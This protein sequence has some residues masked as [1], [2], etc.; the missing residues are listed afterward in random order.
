M[1]ASREG[2][3]RRGRVGRTLALLAASSLAASV[4]VGDA[5]AARGRPAVAAAPARLSDTGLYADVAS[6]TVDPRNVPY[7]PQYPL[8]SDGASKRR[9]IRLPPGAAIDA[10]DPEAWEFP[11]GTR[12]WKEFAW[13][14]RVETRYLERTRTGWLFAAYAWLEDGSDAVRVDERGAPTSQPV[15]PGRTHV[16]PSIVDCKACHQNGR[17]A[18]LG[19]GALQ[20]SPDRDPLAP[21]REPLEPG[22][23]TLP[24]LVSRGLVRGLPRELLASPPRVSAP[25][26]RGRAA[27]GYLH[28]NCSICHDSVGPLSSLGVDL[29]QPARASDGAA[30]AAAVGQPT[31]YRVPG[32]TRTTVWID[33][34]A[35]ASSAVVARM[36]SQS[37]VA[38]MPP[39]GSQRVDEEALALIRAWIELDLHPA[40]T[41]AGAPPR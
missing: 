20:L 1:V 13:D 11:V 33:P 28:A 37:P 26:P 32:A 40:A 35:P 36:A 3:H 2:D 21:H 14:R 24:T 41:A 23:P 31:R 7:S 18:V 29:R 15:A 38:R 34:R 17:S 22:M 4:T 25:T 6:R 16:I 12:L 19:F 10:R 8:W 27:L 9:W 30:P 5:A 39:L